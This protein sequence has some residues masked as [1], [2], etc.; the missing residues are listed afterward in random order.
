[1]LQNSLKRAVNDLPEF[2]NGYLSLNYE[3]NN[4]PIVKKIK[5]SMG[6]DVQIIKD[7]RKLQQIYLARLRA[8]R[9]IGPD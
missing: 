8:R 4:N 2:V 3:K 6:S 1:M 7:V 5:E 9:L